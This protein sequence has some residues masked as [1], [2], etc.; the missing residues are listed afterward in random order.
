MPATRAKRLILATMCLGTFM[1]ILDTSLVNLG[2]H[3]IQEDLQADMTLL[4]WVVDL[5]NL[6]YAVLI[7]TGGT[8]SDLYGRRRIFLLGVLVFAV[9]SLICAVAPNAMTL[10]AGRGIAG[11]GAALELPAALA[12]L[13]V[14]YPD[15]RQRAHAIAVWGGMNGL[16][17]AIGP[18]IGGVLVDAFGWRSLFFAI[19]PIAGATALLG[20]A[21][22]DETSDR[23]GRALDWL[24]QTL[25]V[26]T[27]G[28]ISLAFIEGPNWG[29]LAPSVL[30]CFATGAA[31]LVLFIVVERRA[32]APMLPLSVFDS[33]AFCTSVAD[34]TLMT[35]GMY[36]LLFLL[37]LYLQTV[38]HDTALMAGVALLPMSLTFF[39][40]SLAAGPVAT[41]IGPRVLIGGGMS[42]TGLGMLLLSGLSEQSDYGRVAISLFAVGVGLGLITGPIATAAVANA[43]AA[44]SGLSSGLVHTGRMVGA[45]L[46]VAAL[47]IL[48]GGRA[49][50]AAR[51]VG[52]FIHG[53]QWAFVMGAVAELAGA[54]L[55]VTWFRRDSLESASR[56][57]RSLP[58]RP[59]AGG[60][61]HSRQHGG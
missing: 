13:N 61:V 22:L 56:D 7:L 33:P 43:P 51:D 50:A 34:A 40:V 29:W 58:A 60:P 35:F 15:S 55:A 59:H 9:G 16:A 8:L 10:V 47:G 12:I 25:S 45:T 20:F 14:T 5:Y 36:G 3:R 18:T 39:L 17:M 32:R 26:V 28:A 46:G 41:A 24:G 53:M 57:R 19:L 52:R 6:A 1:A 37:P 48:L 23:D 31:A 30:A 2:L 27:L 42:L 21:C 4:Q 38:Q 49:D 11:V 44:R 54:V